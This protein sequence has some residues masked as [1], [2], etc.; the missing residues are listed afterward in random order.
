V[1]DRV[2]GLEV[3]ADDYVAKPFDLRE[4]L[5]RLRAVLRRRQAARAT[6]P[7]A[8]PAGH[9][10]ADDTS[11]AQHI[12]PPGI[13]HLLQVGDTDRV[14]GEPEEFLT[15]AGHG[16]EA[17]PDRVLATVVFTDIVGSTQRAADLGDRRWGA[18]LAEHNAIVRR[19]LARF[20]GREV[21]AMGDG[22]LAT[23]DGP[24]R[25]VLCARASAE[26]VRSALGI[27][28]RS[29]VHT[30][31][32]ELDREER[33]VRGIAVHVAARIAA[34]AGA[35]EVL[36]SG[37][38][39]DLAAGV[40]HRIPRLRRPR[41]QGACPAGSSC[42]R[43]R[44]EPSASPRPPP[45]FRRTGI[46]DGLPGGFRAPRTAPGRARVE[47]RRGRPR[48]C[49]EVRR[50]GRRVLQGSGVAGSPDPCE[51][52]RRRASVSAA[53]QALR[54]LPDPR[55]RSIAEPV[56][57][58]RDAAGPSGMAPGRH[59]RGRYD[60]PMNECIGMLCPGPCAP[61]LPAGSLKAD[62][63]STALLADSDW[64]TE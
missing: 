48:S 14:G 9:H 36:V 55:A 49:S 22:F 61:R 46:R 56:P 37:T 21:Q 24:A 62:K 42:S 11:G 10:P 35:G 7:S 53:A 12:A 30:G 27:D 47:R 26:G 31:E 28:I 64:V 13:D 50:G 8:E 25:A 57:G 59:D 58:L 32:V 54:A 1:V 18:L 39:R 38:V 4:L 6:A 23:F 15:G 2:V 33:G 44:A 5:A 19:E 3:G 63:V 41:A 51:S 34:L 45:E 16:G 17:D 40:R 29:G 60:P 52:A 20:G 43:R